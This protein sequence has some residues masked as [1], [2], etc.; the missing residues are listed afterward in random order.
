M[1]A[2]PFDSEQL[3]NVIDDLASTLRMLT[4]LVEHQEVVTR[5][6]A[7]DSMAITRNL[8]RVADALRK[9]QATQTGRERAL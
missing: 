3:R 5:N 4:L 1:P 6:A 8:E 9:L 2:I 7:Q